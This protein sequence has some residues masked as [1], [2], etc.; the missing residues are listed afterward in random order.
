MRTSRRGFTL[1]ELLVV[2]AI[3]AILIALLLPAVQQ[4]REAARRTQCRNNLKQI[5][6]ALHNY[7]DTYGRFPP[8]HIFYP[9]VTDNGGHWGWSAFILPF[10]DQ[11]PLYQ[12]MRVGT[13]T[14]GTALATT[15]TPNVQR[16]MSVNQPAFNCPSN[17]VGPKNM[18]QGRAIADTGGTNR[19]LAASTYV[20]ANNSWGMYAKPALTTSAATN[21]PT[22]NGSFYENSNIGIASLRDG[23][24][25]TVVV[26]ERAHRIKNI[27]TKAAVMFGVKQTGGVVEPV[28]QQDVVTATARPTTIN[29]DGGMTF[30]YGDGMARINEES[31]YSLAGF[32]S[33]HPGG[34]HFLMGDGSVTFVTDALDARPDTAAI[35]SVLERLI[36]IKDGQPTGNF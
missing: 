23:T 34:S 17:T 31:E 2:I 7:H 16:N 1:I 27:E 33:Q 21:V 30:G 29:T 25:N 26:G 3:I 22:P 6:L 14:M 20:A 10:V 4:A 5:G 9:G 13:W 12:Q 18:S 8:G 35:D 24:S 32:N 19:N 36:A 11:M 15:G 28:T